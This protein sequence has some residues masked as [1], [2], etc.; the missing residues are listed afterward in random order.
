MVY[1]TVLR[2]CELVRVKSKYQKNKID[3]IY[4]GTYQSKNVG[5]SILNIATAKCLT[6]NNYDAIASAQSLKM[7]IAKNRNKMVQSGRLQK[8][9]KL[10]PS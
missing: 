5:T 3:Q 4:H 1:C 2:V 9:Q 6:T 8:Q 10:S 7:T